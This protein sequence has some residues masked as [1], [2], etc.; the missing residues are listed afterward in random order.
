MG[1]MLIIRL[2]YVDNHQP[3][4]RGRFDSFD[5]LLDRHKKRIS[6]LRKAGEFF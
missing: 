1:K 4:V 3:V 6:D 2:P 5:A